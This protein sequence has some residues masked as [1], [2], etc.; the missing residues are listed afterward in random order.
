[1]TEKTLPSDVHEESGCRLP[2]PK[3]EDLD[4]AAKAIFDQMCNPEGPSL[5]GLRGPGGIRLH[6]PGAAVNAQPLN[7]YLRWE[8]N[9]G[10]R[11]RELAILVT[12]REHDNQFEWAAHEPAALEE[13]VSAE[14]IDIVKNRK[15]TEGLSE[16]DTVVI[17]FGRQLFGQRR[18]SPETFAR[19]LEIFGPRDLVD[20]VSL[21]GMYAATAALLTAFDIQLRPGEQAILPVP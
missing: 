12:A 15:A 7:R 16:T 6:S 17:E 18:V 2:L 8:T 20:L 1:M 3:R 21:M 14:I 13:G 9:F 11:T 10:G 19:A 4:D 5:V